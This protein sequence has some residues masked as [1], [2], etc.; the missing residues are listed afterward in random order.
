MNA[1][2]LG[3]LLV[4]AACGVTLLAVRFCRSDGPRVDEPVER[5]R[6]EVFALEPSAG[7][8]KVASAAGGMEV[9][10]AAPRD[11][12]GRFIFSLVN[13]SSAKDDLQRRAEFIDAF[14]RQTGQEEDQVVM[15]RHATAVAAE[16]WAQAPPGSPV[17]E[18]MRGAL[19]FAALHPAERMHSTFVGV[20]AEKTDLLSYPDIRHALEVLAAGPETE[21]NKKLKIRSNAEYLLTLTPGSDAYKKKSR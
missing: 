19:V 3:S 13:P 8:A 14:I 1:R 5:L 4:L 17:R 20:V 9:F 11:V 2:V 7:A 16:L 15:G 12:R 18:Q 6:A 21:Y 10:N